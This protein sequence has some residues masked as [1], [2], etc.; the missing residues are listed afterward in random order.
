L[1]PSLDE[2]HIVDTEEEALDYIAKRG[3]AQAFIKENRIAYTR[4]LLES[5][6]LPHVSTRPNDVQRKAFFLGYMVNK[7]LRAFLGRIQEDD[8]DYYGKKRL[9]MAGSLL[10][11]HFRQLFRQFTD[12]MKKIL[13]KEINSGKDSLNLSSAIKSDIITRGLRTALATGNWGKDKQG[14]V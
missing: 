2:A 1:R 6:L 10:A 9:D 4:L 14:D 12:V 13:I 3:S 11:S 5:E 8:R 7:L